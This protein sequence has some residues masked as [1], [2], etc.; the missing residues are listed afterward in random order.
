M[1]RAA[2]RA[3]SIAAALIVAVAASAPAQLDPL[4]GEFQ[5]N[6]FTPGNQSDA[7][8]ATD[9][10]GNF[11][12]VWDG[13]ATDSSQQTVFVQ[14]FDRDGAALGTEYE[15][16]T[17]MCSQPRFQPA[18]CRGSSGAGVLAWSMTGPGGTARRIVAQLFGSGGNLLGTEFQVSSQVPADSYES[19]SSVACGDAGDFVVAWND[20]EYTPVGGGYATAGVFARRF[21]SAGGP[22]G[23]EFQ[24]NTYTAGYFYTPVVAADDDRDFVV[25]WSAAYDI[26]GDATGVFGQRFASNGD[27]LGTEFQVNSY[28]QGYQFYPSVSSNGSGDFVVAW[29]DSSN[30]DG[31]GFGVFAQRFAS[32][33]SFA[34]TEFQVN[35]YTT[36]YQGMSVHRLG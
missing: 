5:V 18:M 8:V 20:Y 16:P 1:M 23:T 34:G 26:D 9:A 12:A 32:D 15:V 17:G 28:T 7:D 11:V 27:F 4:G 22:Q 14:R 33:G 29:A 13:P 31:N 36:S 24:V 30:L 6:T 25:V 21:D 2:V 10:Q 19:S 3:S 35:S